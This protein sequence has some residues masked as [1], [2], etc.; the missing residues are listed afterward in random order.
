MDG[1]QGFSDGGPDTGALV[2]PDFIA[3]GVDPVAI[4]AVGLAF[5]RREGPGERIA[6]ASIWELPQLA[7]AVELG[8]GATSPGDITLAGASD[9]LAAELRREMA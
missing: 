1:R 3:V 2:H 7:R 8:L 4:D 6:V 5:L 9:E